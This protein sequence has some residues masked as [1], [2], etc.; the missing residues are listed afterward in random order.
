MALHC[1]H[2]AAV[3]DATASCSHQCAC[4]LPQ[5]AP[6]HPLTPLPLCPAFPR[7]GSTHS[8][9]LSSKLADHTSRR[10]VD[11][12]KGKERELTLREVVPWSTQFRILLG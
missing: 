7:S 2:A 3:P 6:A 11:L 4:P 9:Q 1:S 12:D 10:S 5:A 8:A